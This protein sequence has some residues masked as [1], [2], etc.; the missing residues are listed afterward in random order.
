[1]FVSHMMAVIA[2]FVFINSPDD[3]D[4]LIFKTNSRAGKQKQTDC[5]LSGTQMTVTL[6]RMFSLLLSETLTQLN[7]TLSPALSGL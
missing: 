2:H 3:W 4:E 7:T 1:M 5:S 6:N